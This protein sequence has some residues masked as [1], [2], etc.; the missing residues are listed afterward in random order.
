MK[1]T[2]VSAADEHYFPYLKGLFLSIHEHR[3][4]DQIALASFDLGLSPPQLEELKSMGVSIITPNWDF[5]FKDQTKTPRTLQWLTARCHLPNYFPNADPIL[6][7]DADA[8][9]QDWRAIEL[10][11][12]CTADGS[13]AIVPEIHCAYT[14]IYNLGV[15]HNRDMYDSYVDSVG[16]DLARSLCERPLFNAG[17]FAAKRNSPAWAKWAKWVKIAMDGKVHTFTDQN[18]LNAAIYRDQLSIVPLP[19]WCNWI[20]SQSRPFFDPQKKCF[21]EA[22]PPHDPISILHITS[23]SYAIC[24]IG[25]IGGGSIKLPLNYIPFT[26]ARDSIQTAKGVRITNG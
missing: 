6:W 16:E 13:L 25:I 21:A 17:I 12:H 24:N 9:L 23:K 5:N 14:R 15:V 22:S 18:A 1:P 3:P 4:N 10:F 19:A 26:A 20:C 7:I 8:W 11:I 2:I